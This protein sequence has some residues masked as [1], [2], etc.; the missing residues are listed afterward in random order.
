MSEEKPDNRPFHQTRLNLP[1]KDAAQK[2]SESRRKRLQQDLATTF[3][4]PAGRRVLRYLM[5]ISGYGLSKVGGN[6]QLGM[7]VEKGTFYNASRELV[8]IELIEHMP[9]YILRDVLFG[10][11]SELEGD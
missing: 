7:D 2:L 5:S 4:P 10:T 9:A 6:P 11:E 8:F 1:D 3:A